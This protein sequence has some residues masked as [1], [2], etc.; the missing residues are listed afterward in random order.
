MPVR[1]LFFAVVVLLAITVAAGC[2]GERTDVS[3]S[4]KNINE[5]FA[6]RDVQFKCPDEVDGGKGTEFDCTVKNTDT[7]KTASL[8]MKVV[9]QNGSLAVDFASEADGDAV[10]TVSS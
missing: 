7:G 1:S 4:V 8:K 9:E 10:D 5:L 2:G 3:E 6:K